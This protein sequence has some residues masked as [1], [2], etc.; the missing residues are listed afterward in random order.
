MSQNADVKRLS[1]YI[2]AV[3][4]IHREEVK[5]LKKECEERIQVV[6]ERRDPL[7]LEEAAE[8]LFNINDRGPY[9]IESV[10]VKNSTIIRITKIDG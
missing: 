3:R 6:I 9:Y 4:E 2:E 10:T 5:A 7:S 1:D 8:M